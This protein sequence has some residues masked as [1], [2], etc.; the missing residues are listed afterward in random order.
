MEESPP[1]EG[2]TAQVVM[3]SETANM[4]SSDQEVTINRIQH[5]NLKGKLKLN[6]YVFDEGQNIQEQLLKID[7]R[8]MMADQEDNT[9]KS[10]RFSNINRLILDRKHPHLHQYEDQQH[11]GDEPQRKY[12]NSNNIHDAASCSWDEQ[13]LQL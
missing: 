9:L 1:H 5:N 7:L 8:Q 12:Y 2:Q 6:D 13:E 11:R 3:V 10:Q 4:T